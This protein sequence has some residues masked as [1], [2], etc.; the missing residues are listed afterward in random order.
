VRFALAEPQ[1]FATAFTSCSAS[2]TRP[3]EPSA[4]QVLVDAVDEM[5]ATGAMPAERREAA[6][7]IAWAAVHG[8]A[9]ILVESVLPEHGHVDRLLDDVLA[10]VERAL[11]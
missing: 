1:L 7:W 10:G 11:A 6:P 4:W 9:S 3:D 2:P 8:L 5:V